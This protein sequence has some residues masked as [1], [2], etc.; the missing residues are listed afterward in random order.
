MK[1]RGDSQD[2]QLK[3]YF[4]VEKCRVCPLLD[5]CYKEGTKTKTYSVTIKSTEHKEQEAF[6]QSEILK[7]LAID[8]FMIEAKNSELKNRQGYDR[9][10]NSSLFGM[11]IQ[12]ATTIFVTNLK[13]II[14]LIVEKE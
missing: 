13:R 14:K 8:C 4:D 10:T 7:E 2:T 9:A 1:K 6:Q 11:K 5:G 3:Y 12:R